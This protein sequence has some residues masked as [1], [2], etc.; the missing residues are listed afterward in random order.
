MS[1]S[2][3]GAGGRDGYEKNPPMPLR[4]APWDFLLLYCLEGLGLGRRATSLPVRFLPFATVHHPCDL[5]AIMTIARVVQTF[6]LH[7]DYIILFRV[8]I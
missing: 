4:R 8:L 6:G 5:G 2:S 7:K 3:Q 1:P